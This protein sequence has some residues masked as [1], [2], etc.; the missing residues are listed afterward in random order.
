MQP[1]M[2]GFYIKLCPVIFLYSGI[3]SYDMIKRGAANQGMTVPAAPGAKAAIFLLPAIL[4]FVF[5]SAFSHAAT[6]EGT[7]YDSELEPAADVLMEI[8]SQ[9]AQRLL[10]RDGT[11]TF[12]I[13]QGTYRLTARKGELQVTEEVNVQTAGIF[14]FD[15]FLIP[16]IE[17]ELDLW[18]E[19]EQ[20]LLEEETT[21]EG[22]EVKPF[23]RRYW[24]HIVAFLIIIFLLYRFARARKKYGSLWRF[25]KKVKEEQ[26]KTLEQHKQELAREPG[27]L[28]KAMEIIRKH[29]GRITQKELRREMMPLSEAKVSLIITELEHRGKVEKVK[30]G[31]GNVILV[32]E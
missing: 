13:P 11:Y 3:F 2:A 31:R 21:V 10:S 27:Y 16:D 30:K 17:Q 9:P 4:F 12:E 26:A 15:I 8:D 7:I 6:L 20:E 19:T 29:D 18:G 5:F 32:K 25:R 1:E 14:V 28:E 22:R 24:R 23:F